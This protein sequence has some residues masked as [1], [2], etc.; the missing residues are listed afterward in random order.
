[1]IYK[2]RLKKAEYD[3]RCSDK[4][5]VDLAVE[6]YGMGHSL[7]IISEITG[8]S[9]SKLQRFLSESDVRNLNSVNT[10]RLNNNLKVTGRMVKEGCSL[11][12]VCVELGVS[13]WTVKQYLKQLGFDDPTRFR[14]D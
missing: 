9:K 1:M 11:E 4:E 8:F 3:A 10:K 2:E 13:E 6:L 7:R 14:W 5:G 12:D